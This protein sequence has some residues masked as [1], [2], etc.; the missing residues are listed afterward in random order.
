[1]SSA[2]AAHAGPD[3]DEVV[4]LT[5][6]LVRIPSVNRPELGQSERPAAELVAAWMRERGWSP[7]IEAV[8]E[9]RPNVVCA[10]EGD[11]PG[12]T[13]LF[14]GHTDVVT[15]GDRAEWQR[16]PFGAEIVDGVLWGRGSADMKGGLAAMLCA[17]AAL[18]A[19]RPWPGRIV[20]AVLADEEGMML[21]AKRFVAAG[22]ARGVDAAIVCE[23]E[24]GQLCL[25]QKG[26]IRARVTA[27]GRMA[28]GAMPDRGVNPLP[29]LA[30]FVAAAAE[31]ER[32]L[33]TEVGE[34]PHLG[35]PYVTPTVLR[36]GDPAQINVIPGSG[37]LALD[38]RTVP[39]IDH[40]EL[41]DRLWQAAAQVGRDTRTRL[42]LTVIDDRPPTEIGADEPIARAV[43]LAHRDVVGREPEIGGVPGTTDGTILWRDAGIPVVVY[44][45]G[46]KWIAHQAN[47]HVAVDEL[48]R[49]VEIYRRA[50]RRFL[51]GDLGG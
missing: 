8:A 45:P 49:C 23:P 29:A 31:L 41:I 26:A 50:A 24:A 12:P 38:I 51:E 2:P 11:R 48:R 42:E 14:E 35:R 6:A 1:M 13:L 3:P 9:G 10:L 39:G 43:A 7:R 17:A 15:E 22:H 28:H 25:T 40:E 33:T 5:Q 21:G 27:V 16:D 44:G 19:E 46:G 20:L 37:T 34:H 32:R 18:D 4:R 36:A 47:E 30:G